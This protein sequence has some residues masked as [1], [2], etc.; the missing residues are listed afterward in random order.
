MASGNA[1]K[2]KELTER[3]SAV[4]VEVVKTG[5]VQIPTGDHSHGGGKWITFPCENVKLNLF[6]MTTF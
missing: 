6:S 3:V 2:V 5:E 4:I 1:V